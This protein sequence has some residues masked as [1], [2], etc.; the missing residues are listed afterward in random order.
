MPIGN[1][2]FLSDN[3]GYRN[4]PKR[5]KPRTVIGKHLFVKQYN[6]EYM[7]VQ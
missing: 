5:A 4:P 7:F 2:P 1:P 3:R 6:I